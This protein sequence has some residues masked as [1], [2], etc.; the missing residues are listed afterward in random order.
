MCSSPVLLPTVKLLKVAR[1]LVE[2]VSHSRNTCIAASATN[3]VL[4]HMYTITAIAGTSE[5]ILDCLS[6]CES[7]CLGTCFMFAANRLLLYSNTIASIN[8]FLAHLPMHDIRFVVINLNSVN[9]M[10]VV[11]E[12]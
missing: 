11:W 12:V 3:P 6:A 7:C 10:I 5:S 2:S 1:S 4:P 8:A 9:G